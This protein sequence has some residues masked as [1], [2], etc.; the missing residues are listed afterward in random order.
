MSPFP[1]PR[2]PMLARPF[3]ATNLQ[4]SPDIPRT[5]ELQRSKRTTAPKTPKTPKTPRANRTNFYI[6][7]KTPQSIDYSPEVFQSEKKELN[8]LE[9]IQFF[10]ELLL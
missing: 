10:L 1:K 5:P 4:A 8:R 7:H 6:S 3:H 9:Y 2:E